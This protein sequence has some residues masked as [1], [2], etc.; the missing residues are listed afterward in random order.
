[1]PISSLYM[2]ARQNLAFIGSEATTYN[3][4]VTSGLQA[5]WL[6]RLITGA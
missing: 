1:M 2:L 6:A 4:P 5:E 3:N